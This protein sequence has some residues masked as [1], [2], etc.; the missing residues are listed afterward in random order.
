VEAALKS[1]GDLGRR[2][3]PLAASLQS[4]TERASALLASFEPGKVRSIVDN[5]DA[6]SSKASAVLDQAGTL[7]ADNSDAIHS[8]FANVDAFAQTLAANRANVDETL[9]GFAELGKQVQPIA[10]R[11]ESL[12]TD[13]DNLVKAV[14]AEKVRG[15]VD[16]AHTFSQSLAATATDYETVM[17][18]GAAFAARLNDA[19]KDIASTMADVDKIVKSVDPAKVSGIVDS[20]S[21]VATTVGDNRGA[22][23]EAI[24]NAAGMMAKLNN[25]ADKVDSL[26]VSAQGFLGSPGTKS[27]LGQIGDAAQSIKKLA[28]DLD[29]RVKEISVGLNRFSNSGLKQYEAL[30][31]QAQRVLEDIDR[32]VRSLERNPSQ[33]I[34]GAKPSLPEYRGAQ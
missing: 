10:Q 2:I 3:D 12:S 27:S 20:I 26:I 7:I 21:G 24:R 25:A 29:V 23:D 8:T 14:D 22:I 13:A 18:N 30:A 19:S 4:A 15:V 1:F 9:K 33:I 17:R 5:V 28:D 34:W 11:F 32:A 31:I 16:N 6:A